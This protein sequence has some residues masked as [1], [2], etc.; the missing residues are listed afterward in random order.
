MKQKKVV[1]LTLLILILFLLPLIIFAQQTEEEKVNLA[2]EWLTD[3]VAGKWD[4]L[5]TKQNVFSLLA[6]Q[7]NNTAFNEGN[8]SLYD[9]SVYSQSNNKGKRCW[10][11]DEISSQSQCSLTETALAKIAADEFNQDTEAENIRNWII[12]Q[13]KTFTD[14]HWYLQIDIEQGQRANCSIIYEYNGQ[15]QEEQGFRIWENKTVDI[16]GNSNC[17]SDAEYWFKVRQ[18]R[19][20]CYNKDYTIKCWSGS[21]YYTVSWFYK[22]SPGS[23]VFYVSGETQ[24]AQPG[25]GTAE[26]DP[27]DT[28][29]TSYC[30]TSPGLGSSCDYEGTAWA[31]YALA[32]QGNDEDANVY[33][34]YLITMKENNIK[35]F[36]DTFLYQLMGTTI[37]ETKIK[38]EQKPQGYWLIQPIVYGRNY[39]TAHAVMALGLGHEASNKA[40]EW[41]LASQT[42]QGYWD[43]SDPGKEKV[44]DTAFILWVFWPDFCPTGVGD[45]CED[46]GLEYTCRDSCL[47]DEITV[48]YDCPLGEIC[49][50][51]IGYGEDECI[52]NEG[53]CKDDCNINEF[54]LE[55]ISCPGIKKCCKN[56]L[57][58]DCED[59]VGGEFC[60][61]GQMCLGEE[62]ETA[63][64]FLE[65]CCIGGCGLALTCIEAGGEE[66]EPSQNKYCQAGYEIPASDTD[67]CCEIG[68]C[69]DSSSMYCISDLAGEVCDSTQACIDSSRSIINFITTLDTQYCCIGDCV[70]NEYCS[71]IGE[72]CNYPQECYQNVY[73]ET[74]DAEECCTTECVLG[75]EDE[76]GTYCYDSDEECS[77]GNFIKSSEGLN[78][79]LGG[80]CKKKSVFPWWIIIIIIILL[81]GGIA[82]YFLYFKKPKK[83][84]IKKMFPFGPGP[85]LRPRPILRPALTKRPSAPA[86]MP[87]APKKIP[88]RTIIKR[89]GVVMPP[90]P[91]PQQKM[92]LGPSRIMEKIRPSPIISRISRPVKIIKQKRKRTKTESELEKTLSKLQKITK[93]KG[94]KKKTRKTTRKT[95]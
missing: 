10:G 90:V 72:E 88:T 41:I 13:N 66:C 61:A 9:K 76:G 95:R 65:L 80:T 34:P 60:V 57:D 42:S 15:G 28:S 69:K 59:E 14:I 79:C 67:Y 19:E 4:E 53:M 29:L 83:P 56:Y 47:G 74:I 84:K 35:Y 73:V 43:A 3:E 58:A 82:A 30:L 86:I 32:K 6:L 92:P 48:N 31:A 21:S 38:N 40:E 1:V 39:D 87:I 81:A 22:K 11:P 49:C 24:M 93:T 94:A 2:Y 70:E 68:Y 36:P 78:C 77:G 75:C 63:D 89:P 50:K 85:G 64:S 44:R 8:I 45:D 71:N 52:L 55:L 12:N 17:F 5:N 18:E 20:Q 16:I 27:I 91:K 7:C 54:E 51:I 62:V 33:L 25:Y 23:D 26:P 37:Y 46:Q